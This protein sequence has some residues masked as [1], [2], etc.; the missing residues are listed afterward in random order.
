METFQNSK[1]TLTHQNVCQTVP[2]FIWDSS[3]LN[4]RLVRLCAGRVGGKKRVPID[5]RT[6][7][8]LIIG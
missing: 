5:G 8:E 2:G 1:I 6:S 7:E 4:A 3:G